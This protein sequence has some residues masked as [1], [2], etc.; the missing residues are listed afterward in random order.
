MRRLVKAIAGLALA[1]PLAMLA[2]PALAL[3]SGEAATVVGVL[4]KLRDDLGD[5]AYDE[6]A[7]AIWY[8]EDAA[9]GGHI[10]AAG[11]SQADWTDALDAAMKGFFAA[12][13][14]AEIEAMFASLDDYGDDARFTAEQKAAIGT[15][16][17][18]VRQRLGAWRL[19]GADDAEIMRPHVPRVKELLGM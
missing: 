15:L 5:L 3:T 7:A 12:L 4:D 1:A 2:T 8:E 13:D 10:A 6:E 19:E 17:A 14:E 11:L 16:T 18:E 9:Y